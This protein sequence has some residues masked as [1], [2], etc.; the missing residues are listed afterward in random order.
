MNGSNRI[1]SV[2]V[3][4]PLSIED[5]YYRNE[6]IRVIWTRAVFLFCFR[7]ISSATSTCLTQ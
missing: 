6:D 4:K 2:S 5:I 7:H 1:F 3:I